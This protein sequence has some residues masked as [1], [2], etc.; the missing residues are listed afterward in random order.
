MYYVIGYQ[1]Q[2]VPGIYVWHD[3]IIE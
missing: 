1:L 3:R 2:Y